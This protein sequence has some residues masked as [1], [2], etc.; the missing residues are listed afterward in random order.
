V[1]ERQRESVCERERERERERKERGGK[2][3]ERVREVAVIVLLCAK[4]AGG[5]V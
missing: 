1:R 4:S 3:I 5:E 2:K